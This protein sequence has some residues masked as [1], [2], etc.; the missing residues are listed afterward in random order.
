MIKLGDKVKDP[1]TGFNGTAVSR[2]EY[3][4]GCIRIGIQGPVDKGGKVPDP[5]YFDE[6]QL[7]NIKPEKAK[8]KANHGPKID[9]GTRVNPSKR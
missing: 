2:I 9:P 4:Y 3:L 5:V 8:K 6:P 1:I 7:E